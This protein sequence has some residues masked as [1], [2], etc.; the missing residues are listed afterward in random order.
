MTVT[1]KIVLTDRNWYLL[2]QHIDMHLCEDEIENM[3]KI[4][5]TINKDHP[6]AQTN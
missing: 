5:D 1:C 2:C 3:D 6:P 4:K